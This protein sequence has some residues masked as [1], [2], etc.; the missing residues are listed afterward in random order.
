LFFFSFFVVDVDSATLAAG[1]SSTGAGADVDGAASS[2][3]SD[4]EGGVKVGDM[5]LGVPRGV[6]LEPVPNER[7][8]PQLA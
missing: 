3:E 2:E 1:A 5:R 6:P 4:V 7:D 8:L